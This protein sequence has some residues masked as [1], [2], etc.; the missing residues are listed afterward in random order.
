LTF[1]PWTVN[2]SRS[3]RWNAY[4]SKHNKV[5]QFRNNKQTEV[6]TWDVYTRHGSQLQLADAVPLDRFNISD[7]TPIQIKSLA[8]GTFY[9]DMTSIV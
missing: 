6:G 4:R 1:G 2:H 9:G 7:G 3:G 8:N 5:Y